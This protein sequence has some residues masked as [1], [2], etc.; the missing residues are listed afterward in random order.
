MNVKEALRLNHIQKGL[1]K[2]FKN[3]ENDEIKRRILEE[4]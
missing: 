2:K 1:I 4:K 3:A